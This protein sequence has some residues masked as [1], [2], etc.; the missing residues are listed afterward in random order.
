MLGRLVV[1]AVVVRAP[2]NVQLRL[3]RR[4]AVLPQDIK[5]DWF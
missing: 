1:E 4:A 2:D 3:M 5:P